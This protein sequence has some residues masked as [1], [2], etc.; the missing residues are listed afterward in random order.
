M[1]A[2]Q[3]CSGQ[4]D[5]G[6][7][8]L[9]CVRGETCGRYRK[10]VSFGGA[11]KR[12]EEVMEVARAARRGGGPLRLE[13]TDV[14][15]GVEGVE[16]VA[17]GYTSA[18]AHDCAA[19]APAAS[20]A[21]ASAAELLAIAAVLGAPW[22]DDSKGAYVYKACVGRAPLARGATPQPLLWLGPPCASLLLWTRARR[23]VTRLAVPW[24]P[25]TRVRQAH[26]CA[27]YGCGWR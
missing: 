3:S 10:P 9:A 16:C 6:V 11:V 27:W 4:D 24:R 17:R 25:C 23:G 21:N 1:A 26:L 8:C 14:P 2:A 19:A 7:R 5:V 20:G 12:P 13:C 18:S 22:G 15:T